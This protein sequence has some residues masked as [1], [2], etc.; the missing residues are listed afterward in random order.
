MTLIAAKDAI[1]NGQLRR[2]S[3]LCVSFIKKE[4]GEFASNMDKSSILRWVT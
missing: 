1:G 2:A 3:Q 4:T